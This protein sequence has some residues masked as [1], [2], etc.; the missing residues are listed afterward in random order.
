MTNKASL[1]LHAE[2]LLRLLGK[3]YGTDGSLEQGSRVVRQF[4]VDAGVDNSDFFLYDGSGLSS[5][6]KIAPRAFTRLLS[7]ASRQPW[8]VAW[9]ETL[10]VAGVNGTLDNRFKSSP[11]K[12]R[13]WAKTG[14]SSEVNTLSGYISADSGRMLAF[15]ILVNGRY[16]GSDNEELAID[17]IAEAIAAAE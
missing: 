11:L 17:H 5:N 2:L 7:Y 12:A 13:I 10:P 8:G 15:S 14:T 9:R 4:M 16:P 1:N 3:L 6:D